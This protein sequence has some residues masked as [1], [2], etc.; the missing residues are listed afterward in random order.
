MQE[1]DALT[2]VK[3]AIKE[4][5]DIKMLVLK[6][7]TSTSELAAEV[8]GVKTGQIAKSLCFLGDGEPFLV[9][10]VG[11]RK[12]DAKKLGKQIGRKKVKFAD[13]LTVEAATG[14]SP[15]GVCP[16]AL[17][18]D[19]PV[20]LDNSLFSYDL[21]YAAAGTCNSIASVTPQRLKDITGAEIVDASMS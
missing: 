15:G 9:V 14:F 19:I 18:T 2:R 12:M 13:A 4:Y 8:L 11:D 17:L 1:E 16:F 20:Y 7:D 5:D 10:S 3:E 21:V 6:S